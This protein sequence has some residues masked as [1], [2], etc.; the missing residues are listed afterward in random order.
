MKNYLMTALIALVFGFA[1]AGLWSVSGL[2]NGQTRDY[3]L[4]NPQI[5]PEMAEAY[6]R[7]E[8]RDRLAQVSDEVTQPF[9][10]A[11]LGNPEGAKVL[12]KFTDYGCTY[13]RQ[14]VEGI[15]ELIAGDPELKVVVREWPIF[16]GSEQAA[17]MALAA[18]K[19]G[20]YSAFYHAM[21]EQGTPSEAG[22][23]RAARIAGLDMAAAQAFAQS[24]EATA[25]LAKTMAFA[26]TLQFTGTPSWIAG[27]E[28]IEGLV[29][30]ERLA[31]ALDADT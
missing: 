18:A 13:C 5:L 8:A 16:E 11:V 15:D 28:V 26:R 21:F 12:V 2:G 9:A 23:E 25:E 4:A 6:Q 24:D 22:I 29:P 27:G 14:S 30:A 7:G 3:L 20:K 1:G 17:R 19:Q 31:E 10:G